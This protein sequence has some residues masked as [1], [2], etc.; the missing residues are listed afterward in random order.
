MDRKRAGL[1]SGG[2][3]SSRY[4][5]PPPPRYD[6]D[7][8]SSGV[9]GH[10]GSSS[11]DYRGSKTL[12]S[13]SVSYSD[14]RNRFERGGAAANPS[15][16][17]VASSITRRVVQE[18][19]IRRDSR[20][21]PSP[22]PPPPRDRVDDRR[23][24]DRRDERYCSFTVFLMDLAGPCSCTQLSHCLHAAPTPPPHLQVRES[25]TCNNR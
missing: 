17:S 21:P 20:L 7:S 3:G 13:S 9:G 23:V 24:I 14:N 18:V 12:T 15:L 19:S 5:A 4:E 11:S 16:P 6:V 1:S 25:L 8:K 10:Y 22:P 2:D